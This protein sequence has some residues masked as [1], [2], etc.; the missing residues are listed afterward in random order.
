MV[1]SRSLMIRQLIFLQSACMCSAVET[2]IPPH[3]AFPV[4]LSLYTRM[5]FNKIVSIRLL[6]VRH[7]IDARSELI[8]GPLQLQ[9]NTSSLYCM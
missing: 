4:S 1:F 3:S 5:D 2:V 7:L 9:Y 6:T 8:R